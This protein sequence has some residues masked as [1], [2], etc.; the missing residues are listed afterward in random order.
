M[1]TAIAIHQPV[2]PA[3]QR[4]GMAAAQ[5]AQHGGDTVADP[6]VAGSR[7]FGW[8]PTDVN[9]DG[10]SDGDDQ[11]G[12]DVA[13]Q[14]REYHPPATQEQL[15]DREQTHQAGQRSE[16]QVAIGHERTAEQRVKTAVLQV[17]QVG[18]HPGVDAVLRSG[19]PR[20]PTG[21]RRAL[22]RRDVTRSANRLTSIRDATTLNMGPAC[23][24]PVSPVTTPCSRALVT[25]LGAAGR[26]SPGKTPN[27][28][29]ELAVRSKMTT[30]TD[31][32]PRAAVRRR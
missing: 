24:R 19:P 9:C 20:R 17:V 11:G 8:E 18:A 32:E 26:Q 29:V 2:H 4:F 25:V 7:G 28:N 12:P 23:Y 10:Q 3:R 5:G 13:E 30:T 6:D 27:E 1:S 16:D 31:G 21:R 15:R 14:E 22:R